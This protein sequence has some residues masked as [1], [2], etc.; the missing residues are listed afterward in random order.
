MNTDTI[1]TLA[2]F[3]ASKLNVNASLVATLI[4]QFE[5]KHSKSPKSPKTET[6]LTENHGSVVIFDEHVEGSKT[7]K[8]AENG[9]DL[10]KLAEAL[11]KDP[12]FHG[13]GA[14]KY[15]VELKGIG[16]A[17]TISKGSVVGE[18]AIREFVKMLGDNNIKFVSYS[19]EKS[20]LNGYQQYVSEN[21][22][23][24]REENKLSAAETMS[25]LASDW[26]AS[27]EKK[28]VEAMK[29]ALKALEKEKK[30]ASP[31]SSSPQ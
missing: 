5:M 12:R 23:R 10:S 1:A 17:V 11:K 27:D 31:S 18:E 9:I 14:I 28:Q 2:E 16:K 4:T 25:K 26:H 15:I 22:I 8:F 20:P 7:V 13:K 30:Q 29:L 3:L 6:V 24:V 19:P 21:F